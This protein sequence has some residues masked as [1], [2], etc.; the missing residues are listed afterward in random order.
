M[1]P[2]LFF[3]WIKNIFKRIKRK[4][5]CRIHNRIKVLIFSKKDFASLFF[6]FLEKIFIEQKKIFFVTFLTHVEKIFCNFN[7][8]AFL[9]F[10]N[11]NI[12]YFPKRILF[13]N[14]SAV[15]F[16][17][18]IPNLKKNIFFESIQKIIWS[19]FILKFKKN[20]KKNSFSENN[21]IF[22]LLFNSLLIGPNLE[23]PKTQ[24]FLEFCIDFFEINR[25]KT[26]SSYLFL[27]KRFKCQNFRLFQETFG[28]MIKR[29]LFFFSKK[30]GYIQTRM[31]KFNHTEN[32]IFLKKNILKDFFQKIFLKIPK[33]YKSIFIRLINH[34][35]FLSR[36]FGLFTKFKKIS[37]NKKYCS[38]HHRSLLS[39]KSCENQ[40]EIL[41]FSFMNYLFS[42]HKNKK[43]HKYSDPF[44]PNFFLILSLNSLELKNSSKN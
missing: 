15:L 2:S 42:E 12:N 23:I 34:K 35:F 6:F 3:F 25:K 33:K 39:K 21:K 32:F 22:S 4:D 40:S 37:K 24:I 36:F 8:L 13:S 9:V 41:T 31:R 28:F 19:F 1:L 44:S 14:N 30:V 18:K 16:S 43:R 5:R 26:H 17:Q 20:L 38:K 29:S 7:I 27:I 11:I 10:N